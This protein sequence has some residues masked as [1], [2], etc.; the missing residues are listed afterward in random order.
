MEPENFA[1]KDN[2]PFQSRVI[3][4]FLSPVIFSGSR[5][6]GMQS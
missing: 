2:G 5:L 3:C 1:L 6:H 4:R